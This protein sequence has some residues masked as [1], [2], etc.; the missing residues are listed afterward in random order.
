MTNSIL[1]TSR[2]YLRQFTIED[3]PLIMQLNTAKVLK[4]VDERLPNDIEDAKQIITNII[5][6]QYELYQL[7]RFAVH[8]KED[9]RFVGWCGLKFLQQDNEI[10]LGYRFME[11][12]WG[13]GFATESALAIL[14]WGFNERKLENIIGRAHI[15]N[16][17][18]QNVL[19]KIGLLYKYDKDEDGTITK[20]Y[21][22]KK[23]QYKQKK[24][25]NYIEALGN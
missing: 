14:A 13:K 16:V 3:A 4:Y 22:L 10:D 25:G 8:V 17:A 15:D 2:L 11:N 7:G 24:E 21:S 6:P 18:S 20:V 9:N 19:Q 1:Q 12:Q 23:E 5:L